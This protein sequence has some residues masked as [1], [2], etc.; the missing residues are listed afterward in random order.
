M[1]DEI[2]HEQKGLFI[3]FALHAGFNAGFQ[4]IRIYL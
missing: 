3:L 1:L 2:I 4:V